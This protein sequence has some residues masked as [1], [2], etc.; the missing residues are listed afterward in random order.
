MRS[1]AYRP[2]RYSIEEYIVHRIANRVLDRVI[3][4]DDAQ[5]RSN[6][7]GALAGEAV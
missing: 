3:G 2:G 6:R 1:G 7:E 5:S 4:Q